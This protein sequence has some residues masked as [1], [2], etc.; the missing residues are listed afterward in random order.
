MP[1]ADQ[2]RIALSV[3]DEKESK[4]LLKSGVDVNARDSYGDQPL[5]LPPLGSGCVEA[6]IK[7]GADPESTRSDG[8]RALEVAWEIGACKTVLLL[9]ESGASPGVKSGSLESSAWRMRDADGLGIVLMACVEGREKAVKAGLA[10]GI[11]IEERSRRGSTPLMCAAMGGQLGIVK[12]LL[13][14]GADVNAVRP[15]GANAAMMAV[16]HGHADCLA[17]IVRAGVDI[18]QSSVG[19]SSLADVCAKGGRGDMMSVI[20]SVSIDMA[21]GQSERA[22]PSAQAR[23]RIR[24]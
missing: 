11:S 13:A 9:L 23:S 18:H 8:R 16:L 3:G 14:A 15:D 21:L 20:D 12:M 6:L 17:E 1:L 22:M 4:R 7:A 5:A 19:G 2:L 24:L 10:H